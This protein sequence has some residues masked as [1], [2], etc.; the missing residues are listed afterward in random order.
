MT[1]ATP[2]AAPKFSEVYAELASTRDLSPA[3]ARAVFDAIFAGSWTPSQIGGLLVLLRERGEDADTI[4]AAAGAMR[5]AMLPVAH[6]FSKL[7]D[8]CGTGGDGSGS[9]NLSTGAAL[10]AAAAG[11]RVAKHGNRA[12]TSRSGSADVLEALGIPLD[13]P[14]AAQT[15]VLNEAGIAFL[16]AQAHHPA[17]RHVGP[18]RKELGI[19][20]IFNLL[21]PLSNPAGVT[22]QL[23]GA[24]DDATRKLLAAALVKLGVQRA[25]VVRSVDG[26]D[27]VSPFAET[28]VT[29]VHQGELREHS[30]S[31]ES[32]G[33]APSSAGAIAGGEPSENARAL[34]AILRGEKHPAADAVALNAAAALVVFDGMSEREAGA[35]ARE[36]LASGK[37]FK[38][39]ETWSAA[40]HRRRGQGA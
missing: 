38:T 29:E 32:F 36:I 35:Q 37:A 10:V 39:L 33:F 5:A 2:A 16:F 15:E 13:L 12:A 22:H 6:G 4:A 8:T 18:V 28:R 27:E 34:K 31:P 20:T 24:P 21:G 11:V 26:L 30:I 1:D 17:M 14:S 23:L 3:R 25:W 9:L 7:L 19:R 40:A